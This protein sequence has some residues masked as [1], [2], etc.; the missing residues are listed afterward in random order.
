MLPS[1]LLLSYT[2]WNVRVHKVDFSVAEETEK[3]LVQVHS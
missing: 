2:C 3:Y 1:T